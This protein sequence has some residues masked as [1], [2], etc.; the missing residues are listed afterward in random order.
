MG[1]TGKWGSSAAGIG[2]GTDSFYEYLQKSAKLFEDSEM[3]EMFQEAYEGVEEHLVW[4]GWHVEADMIKGGA[5]SAVVFLWAGKEVGMGDGRS[6]E[7]QR[8]PIVRNGFYHEKWVLTLFARA[9]SSCSWLCFDLGSSL[10]F[11]PYY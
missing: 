2:A 8:L 1:S 5:V 6:E 10:L 7:V 11:P 3:E 4:N 9:I